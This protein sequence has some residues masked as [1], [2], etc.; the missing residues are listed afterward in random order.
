MLPK[1]SSEDDIYKVGS[2]AI[3]KAIHDPNNPFL[4]FNLNIFPQ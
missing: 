3:I 1:I 2:L 4:P